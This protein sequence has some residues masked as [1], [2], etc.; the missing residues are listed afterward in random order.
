LWASGRFVA[1]TVERVLAASA[2]LTLE[3][4]KINI[5]HNGG[6]Y[7]KH[8]AAE[9]R[10]R[11]PKPTT[12]QQIDAHTAAWASTQN[13]IDARHQLLALIFRRADAAL[14]RPRSERGRVRRALAIALAKEAI[15]I[16]RQKLF[17]PE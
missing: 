7:A 5:G 11:T 6:R 8:W 12:Q 17:G 15:P 4:K 3:G 10:H 14:T 1:K 9:M 16:L 13:E 2:Q